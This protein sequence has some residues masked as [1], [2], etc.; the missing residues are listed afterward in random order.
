MKKQFIYQ[1]GMACNVRSKVFRFE[2]MQILLYLAE[3]QKHQN[4]P[5]SQV[6]LKS[7]KYSLGEGKKEG[8]LEREYEMANGNLKNLGMRRMQEEE[9]W[10]ERNKERKIERKMKE[11]RGK[12]GEVQ[13]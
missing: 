12:E 2:Y 11:D 13:A 6:R 3:L 10:K 5:I 7:R 9:R 4:L 8:A 1:N